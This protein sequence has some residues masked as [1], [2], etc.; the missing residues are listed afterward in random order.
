MT[1]FEITDV[2]ATGKSCQRLITISGIGPL[3]STAVVAAI[4]KGEAYGWGRDFAVWLGLV[5]GQ[6]S[7]GGGPFLDVSQIAG[8][9]ICER[10]S[11][12]QHTS[13]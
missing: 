9:N 10:S 13:S 5:P 12:R 1:T 4:G 11:C 7:T 8:T 6:N 2:S 3:I